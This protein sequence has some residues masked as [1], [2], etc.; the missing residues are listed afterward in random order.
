M[1][2]SAI[3]FP[4]AT[5]AQPTTQAPVQPKIDTKN[6]DHPK[7]N[8]ILMMTKELLNYSDSGGQLGWVEYTNSEILQRDLRILFDLLDRIRE[9]NN[10]RAKKLLVKIKHDARN[11]KII[12]LD[13]MLDLTEALIKDNSY[14]GASCTLDVIRRAGTATDQTLARVKLLARKMESKKIDFDI[15]RAEDLTETRQYDKA[16]GSVISAAGSFRFLDHVRT[17]KREHQIRLCIT[18]LRP[19]AP[20]WQQKKLDNINK[21]LT[22]DPSQKDED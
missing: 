9:V 13:D 1:F 3:K 19:Y 15:N 8:N 10:D 18:S 20:A 2:V 4:G 16:Y 17:K 21:N 7:R 14:L 22:N 11:S 6:D 5:F 12:V